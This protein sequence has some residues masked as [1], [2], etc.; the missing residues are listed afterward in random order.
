MEEIAGFVGGEGTVSG[1]EG[2][3]YQ[4]LA[5]LYERIERSVGDNKTGGDVDTLKNFVDE[6]KKVIKEQ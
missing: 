6:A 1:T 5:R 4:G 3:I 2:E